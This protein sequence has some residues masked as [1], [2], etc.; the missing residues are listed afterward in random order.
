MTELLT[1]ANSIVIAL[2]LIAGGWV[3]V[4]DYFKAKAKEKSDAIEAL[5]QKRL[6]EEEAKSSNSSQA[7]VKPNDSTSHP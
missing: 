7:E 1:Y 5:V 3:K 4:R 6:K 2:I